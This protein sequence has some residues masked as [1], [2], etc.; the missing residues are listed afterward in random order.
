M[1]QIAAR[2]WAGQVN[3]GIFCIRLSGMADSFLFT[4]RGMSLK[5]DATPAEIHGQ[6]F[7]VS[8]SKLTKRSERGTVKVASL[9]H[10]QTGVSSDQ[11][12]LQ[13]RRLRKVKQQTAS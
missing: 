7:S 9:L 13:T 3:V 10:P 5:N 8:Y 4:D 1:R 2:T 11:V 6:I 12:Y